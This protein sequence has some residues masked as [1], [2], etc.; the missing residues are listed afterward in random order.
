MFPDRRVKPEN[1]AKMAIY[2]L[3]PLCENGKGVRNRK[4]VAETSGFLFL[5]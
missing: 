5:Q 1:T 4:K 3:F 2:G